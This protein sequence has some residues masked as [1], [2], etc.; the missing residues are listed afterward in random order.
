MGKPQWP[1]RLGMVRG[2]GCPLSPLLFAITIK[3]LA[4]A[5]C[6]NDDI[7]GIP[8]P[9]AHSKLSVYADDL[10]LYVTQPQICIPTFIQELDRF[11]AHSNFKLNISKTEALNISV[12]PTVFDINSLSIGN[13]GR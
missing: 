12:P 5:I 2:Q 6:Q 11:G 3:H 7:H 8:I 10:L 1:L 9:S 4:Q 13:P